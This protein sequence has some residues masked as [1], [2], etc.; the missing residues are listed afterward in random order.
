MTYQDKT[1]TTPQR[2]RRSDDAHFERKWCN[3]KGKT[4]EACFT[5]WNESVESGR[6]IVKLHKMGCIR[7]DEHSQCRTSECVATEKRS[8]KGVHFCCCTE[9]ECNRVDN[10]FYRPSNRTLTRRPSISNQNAVESGSGMLLALA[11]GVLALVA[12]VLALFLIVFRR[13]I[14]RRRSLMLHQSRSRAIGMDEFTSIER[15]CAENRALYQRIDMSESCEIGKGRFGVVKKAHLRCADRQQQSSVVAIKFARDDSRKIWWNEVQIYEERGLKRYAHA[16]VLRYIGACC[17]ATESGD[18]TI[19]LR[20]Y[21]LVS[22][23][24][25]NGSLRDY[26]VENELDV[27][28]AHR[29]LHG[30]LAGLSFLHHEVLS[31]KPQ[32]AHR[33]F[34]SSNVLIKDDLSACVSDFGLAVAFYHE[35]R[36]LG[37]THGQVCEP[38]IC[39]KTQF[40]IQW[41]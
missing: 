22:D 26:L 13:S 17:A 11:L 15:F 39:G 32:I 35:G 23:Y 5:V 37:D 1:T 7:V 16:G 18:E 12:A 29:I 34:K 14:K 28:V 3:L 4:N 36:H 38:R 10:F 41:Q 21:C 33:D 24:H 6:R 20:Q 2:R 25:R 30:A 19:D 31:G 27:A 8:G 40:C 9:N